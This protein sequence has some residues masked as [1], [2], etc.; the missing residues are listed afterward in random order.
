MLQSNA[1]SSYNK[2]ARDAQI[3]GSS[4]HELVKIRFDELQKAMKQATVLIEK[5]DIAAK[6]ERISRAL[7]ILNALDACLDFDEGG[8]IAV[9]LAQIYGHCKQKVVTAHVRNDVAAMNEAYEIIADIADAWTQIG[10]QV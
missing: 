5:G 4:P 7:N 3:E 6:S 2:V 1:I 8:D 9:S 10:D